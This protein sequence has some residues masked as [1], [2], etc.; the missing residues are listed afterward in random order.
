MCKGVH[1]SYPYDPVGQTDT[2]PIG[3]NVFCW[4][5]FD[6]PIFGNH[7]V[8]FEWLDIDGSLVETYYHHI[9]LPEGQ[10]HSWYRVWSRF[11]RGDPKWYIARVGRPLTTRAFCDDINVTSETWRVLARANSQAPF[12]NQQGKE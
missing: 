5:H 8:Y 7:I 4:L 9:P 1:E 10:L 11:V 2:F 3:A 6:G 12:D